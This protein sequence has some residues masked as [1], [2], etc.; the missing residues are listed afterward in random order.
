MINWN[1]LFKI[2]IRELSEA[3][4]KHLVV[5]AL[6]VQQ[7]LIKYKKDKHY[8]RIYTEFPIDEGKICDV[9]IENTR[10][11]E[12]YAYEIQ[13]RVT[14]DWLDKTNQIYKD[15]EVPFCSSDLVII[16][17][18]ELSDDIPTLTKQIKKLII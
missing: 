15:W 13:E 18:S 9:Y 2:K 17:L 1:D 7:L 14:P 12:A 3:Q 16:N 5:K 4:T 6:V 10:K 8:L 11:K